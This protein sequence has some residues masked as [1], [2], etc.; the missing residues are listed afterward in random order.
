M[1]ITLTRDASQPSQTCTLGVLMV[2]ERKF[3]TMERPWVPDP[4]GGAAGKPFHSCIPAGAYRI[5]RRETEARGK[6][7]ILSNPS[8]G[9]YRYPQDVP[10]G[11]RGRALILVH[12]ANWAEELYGC[13]A[14]GKARIKAEGR[15]MVTESRAAMNELRTLLGNQLDLTLEIEQK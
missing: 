8:L 7:F 14:P 6:H 2:G 3:F 11:V 15:W 12:P 13:I 5:E 4:E 1:I 9:V 10:A